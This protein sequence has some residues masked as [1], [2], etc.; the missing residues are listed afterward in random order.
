MSIF[1]HDRYPAKRMLF[2]TIA[3]LVARGDYKGVAKLISVNPQ[4]SRWLDE[5]E[6][7]LPILHDSLAFAKAHDAAWRHSIEARIKKNKN[8]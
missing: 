8:K 6:N 4:A 2:A 3:R 5:D 1:E 7:G